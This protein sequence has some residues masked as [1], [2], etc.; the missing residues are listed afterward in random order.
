[1]DCAEGADGNDKGEESDAG[2]E[3]LEA[4][5]EDEDEEEEDE[6]EGAEVDGDAMDTDAP[7]E[8]GANGHQHAQPADVM[9]H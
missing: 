7:T 2:S 8:N 9:V 4:E 6:E 5:S 1:M 3:D